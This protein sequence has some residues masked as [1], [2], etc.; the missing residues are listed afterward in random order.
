VVGIL[1]PF[2]HLFIQ[3]IKKT[4]ANDI[5]ND[6]SKRLIFFHLRIYKTF[7]TNAIACACIVCKKESEQTGGKK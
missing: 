3:N 7:E 1:R 4:L 6:L 2:D 5:I